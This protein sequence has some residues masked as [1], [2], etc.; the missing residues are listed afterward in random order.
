MSIEAPQH[1]NKENGES[2]KE[3]EK[4]IKDRLEGL[5][6]NG[7]QSK[8]EQA[9]ETPAGD[10]LESIR[11]K[12][13]ETA[14]KKSELVTAVNLPDDTTR[15]QIY[16]DK[17]GAHK[18]KL[19]EVQSNLPRSDRMFS[20]VIH[21]KAVTVASDAAAQTIARP[22]S[23]FWGGLFA[24]LAT[25]S[26]YFTAKYIGFQYNYLISF[27]SFVGGYFV[28]LIIELVLRLVRRPSAV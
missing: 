21:T 18:D 15:Q 6:K 20:K 22:T 16:L 8:A 17:K 28:G 11:N 2:G 19:K 25:A 9:G 27:I 14:T 1:V 3:L 13:N 4:A 12:I 26:L 10:Q 5:A 23:M 7:E 24:C